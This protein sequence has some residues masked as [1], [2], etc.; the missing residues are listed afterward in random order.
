MS[1]DSSYLWAWET[2]DYVG[3]DPAPR[4]LAALI[5]AGEKAWKYSVVTPFLLH[6]S[7]ERHGSHLRNFEFPIPPDQT[8]VQEDGNNWHNKI[9]D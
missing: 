1:C 9:G 2:Q 3:G 5:S 6:W 8:F 4:A 7:C